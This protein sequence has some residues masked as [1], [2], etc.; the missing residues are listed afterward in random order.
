MNKIK[1]LKVTTTH[2]YEVGMIDEKRT[3]INGWTLKEV[4][5]DWFKRFPISY[6]HA[7]RDGSQIGGTEILHKIEVVHSSEE[8]KKDM[9]NMFEKDFDFIE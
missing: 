6:S 4:V 9:D 7:T 3:A 5:H 8:F 2:Y 1:F